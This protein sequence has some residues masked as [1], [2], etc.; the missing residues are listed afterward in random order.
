MEI[1]NPN[2]IATITISRSVKIIDMAIYHKPFNLV[3]RFEKNFT[4]STLKARLPNAFTLY[5]SKAIKNK[6][7]LTPLPRG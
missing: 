6:S 1:N 7:I 3:K 4:I 5:H 2:Q